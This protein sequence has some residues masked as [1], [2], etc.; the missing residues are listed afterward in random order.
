MI[1]NLL[2]ALLLFSIFLNVALYYDKSGRGQRD[3]E[4]RECYI[5]PD[6]I[7]SI[8]FAITPHPYFPRFSAYSLKG[9]SIEFLDFYVGDSI[10]S[11][12][13]TKYD[14]TMPSEFLR[15][16]QKIAY[17][18][19]D[20][21][22]MFRERDRVSLFYRR[23]DKKIVYLR[24]KNSHRNSVQETFLFETEGRE[25]YVTADGVYLQ[26]CITN[27]PF[28]GCPQV[29]FTTEHNSLVPVFDLEP[30]SDI[31]LPFLA[32]LMSASQSSRLGGEVEFI[33]S[34]HMIRAVYKGLASINSG[35]KKDSLYK[36]GTLIGKGG[37]PLPDRKKGVV[38]YLRRRDGSV[39]SPYLF[40]HTERMEVDE[41]RQTNLRIASSFY[42]KWYRSGISFEE[43]YY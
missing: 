4:E 35:L 38:Y 36:P 33:Y 15:N 12:I 14:I 32:K 30:F 6:N 39:I 41:N 34:N 20:F 29:G 16:I 2:Y 19:N 1:R 10:L 17:F 31:R 23:D 5:Y 22:V 28:S 37:Y 42:S 27:G 43:K 26:P 13:E 8:D 40:H 21:R 24:F 11:A 9:E 18:F 25:V 3:T 7:S